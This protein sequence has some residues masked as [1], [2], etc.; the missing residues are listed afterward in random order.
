ME[1]TITTGNL[2]W[3]VAETLKVDPEYQR[4]LNPAWVRK[5]ASE[6]DPDVMGVIVASR[7]G[8]GDVFIV[9]GQH[10]VAAILEMGWGDQKIPCNV[11]EGLSI[12]SEAKV[13]WK[14]QTAS[15]RI[16]PRSRFKARL[17]AGEP[18]ALAMQRIASDHGYRIATAEGATG[19]KDIIAVAAVEYIFERGEQR[20]VEV[21][22]LIQSA[23]G[24]SDERI[25]L[26]LIGGLGKFCAKY[27]E[28]YDRDRL[29]K[30]L[31]KHSVHRVTALARDIMLA[32][33]TH[34]KASSGMA[35]LRLY[36]TGLTNNRLPAWG[37]SL[38][39]NDATI[40]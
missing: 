16:S 30:V 12:E 4:D 22:D 5:I 37:D 7:R 23:Y 2:E 38:D 34:S 20:L 19:P 24:D 25:T 28:H 8:S 9:D 26:Q 15:Q 39:D 17:I 6:F 1:T 32:T 18:K 40:E 36:N 33:G 3:I 29:V 11:Y 35:I 21:M 27:R 31:K 14:P 13:F 10:R